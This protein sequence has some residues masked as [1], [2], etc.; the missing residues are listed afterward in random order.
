MHTRYIIVCVCVYIY[1]ASCFGRNQVTK[2]HLLNLSDIM[3]KKTF[4]SKIVIGTTT[5]KTVR[6]FSTLFFPTKSQVKKKQLSR[7]FKDRKGKN[8]CLN[9]LNS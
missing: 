2:Y 7:S 5:W 9:Y 1:T 8:S 3:Q 4:L 6:D